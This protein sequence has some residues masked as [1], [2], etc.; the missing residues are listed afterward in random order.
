[1]KVENS[2]NYTIKLSICNLMFSNGWTLCL[3]LISAFFVLKP[4]HYS[5]NNVHE[6]LNFIFTRDSKCKEADI[7]VWQSG[8]MKQAMN[9]MLR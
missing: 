1:M 4:T 3:R 5:T 2:R 8:L 6:T 7:R 9:I